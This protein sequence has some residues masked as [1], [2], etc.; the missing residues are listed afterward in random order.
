MNTKK[1]EWLQL[2]DLH[3]FDSTEWN[4]MIEGYK[5]LAKKLKP[6]FLVVTGDFI[7]KT[8]NSD[9]SYALN[10]L[11]EIVNMFNVKKEDVFLVPGNHDI[12]DY[13]FRDETINTI[14]QNIDGDPDIYLKY[15][16][17]SPSLLSAFSQYKSFTES[18]YGDTISDERIINPEGVFCRRWKDIINIIMLNTSL[19]SNGD[20]SHKEIVDI[21]EL[22]KLS[23]TIDKSLPT[24][25]L[26]HHDPDSIYDSQKKQL[27]RIFENINVKAYLCGD[28]HKEDIKFIEKYDAFE[29]RIPCFIC[30]KSAV[31]NQDNYSDVGVIDYSLEIDGNVYVRPYKWGEKFAFKKADD[32][33]IDIDQDFSF[34]FLGIKQN[35]DRE[36]KLNFNASILSSIQPSPTENKTTDVLCLDDSHQFYANRIVDSYG[37]PFHFEH[38][39]YFST[40][41]NNWNLEFEKDNITSYP[42]QI[43]SNIN[44]AQKDITRDLQLGKILKFYGLR[45]NTF[46]GGSENNDIIK[47]LKGN[48]M[49]EIKLLVSNPFSEEVRHRLRPLFST[50]TQCERQWRTIYNV[51]NTLKEEYAEQKNAEIRF[52]NNPLIYRLIIT[53][54]SLYFGYYEPGKDSKDS[55]IYR[56]SNDSSTYRTYDSFYDYQWKKADHNLPTQIPTQYSF[57]QNKGQF[58][59]CPSLV[60]NV[61]SECNMNCVYCPV[62]GENLRRIAHDKFVGMTE[63]RSLIKKYEDIVN[64]EK[65]DAIIRIT[66]GEPLLG[67][68]N[69]KKV[70]DIFYQANKFKKIVLCTNGL[71]LEE[72]YNRE[73]KAWEM[74]KSKLLL[75]VSLDT[76][77][78]SVFCQITQ[79]EENGRELLKTVTKNIRFAKEKGFKIELNLV[80]THLNLKSHEDILK[81]FDFAKRQG[82]VGLKVLTVNDFGG[83]VDF[84]QNTAEL[85]YINKILSNTITQLLARGYEEKELFLYDNK[86]IQMRRFVAMTEN[87]KQCTL[88]IVDHRNSSKSITPYRTFSSFCKTCKYYSGNELMTQEGIKLCAT[89]IMSIS[90]SSDGLLSPCRLCQEKGKSIKNKKRSEIE[91]I[92]KDSFKAFTNCFHEEIEVES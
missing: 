62:G 25:V 10:F 72:A 11:N 9:Y 40:K 80:A 24:I 75:K 56:F 5:R 47:E 42:T 1:I 52:H 28:T 53:K 15:K 90:L 73:F 83:H 21:N 12:Q 16:E 39:Y 43:Y 71:F 89:G 76:L 46:Y 91:Q 3:I 29:Q 67:Q 86:G 81:V 13:S 30:G 18:F 38:D 17:T 68:E 57:L 88:T 41:K 20:K 14:K 4:L 49:T 51:V 35:E 59:V 8:K 26:A 36:T 60:I 48:N 6:N 44:S 27:L 19:I 77:D 55:K 31:E 50:N 61:T 79:T 33:I 87:N 82:L 45:G 32:F 92:I 65:G 74:V 23:K 2:S 63:I 34:P 85:E 69:Q 70:S 64:E 7:H 78:P 22:S 84:E 37:L 66:G 54:Q 58:N